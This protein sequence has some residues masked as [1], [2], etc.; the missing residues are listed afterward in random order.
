MEEKYVC[1][2][3]DV[4]LEGYSNNSLLAYINKHYD[5]AQP[6]IILKISSSIRSG[7][8]DKN[9]LIFS[10]DEL[11][12]LKLMGMN[13]SHKVMKAELNKEEV[14]ELIKKVEIE[15]E[16]YFKLSSKMSDYDISEIL[17]SSLDIIPFLDKDAIAIIKSNIEDYHTNISEEMSKYAMIQGDISNFFKGKV[18]IGE[19]NVLSSLST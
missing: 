9:I 11:F 19:Y 8:Q 5:S 17:Y 2:I 4:E 1:I 12:Y 14:D 7:I 18:V 15:N 16:L 6:S 3:E 13:G 10:Y